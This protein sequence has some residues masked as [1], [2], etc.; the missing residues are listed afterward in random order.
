LA[1]AAVLR[2]NI[3]LY[4][5]NRVV[6]KVN[7]LIAPFAKAV[8]IQLPLIHQELK[9]SVPVPLFPWIQKQG[10]IEKGA[11]RRAYGL[12][13]DRFTILVFGG[14]QGAAFLNQLVPA[15]G[16]GEWQAIHMAGNEEAATEVRALY[17]EAGIVAAVKGFES[18]MGAAYQA[19]DLAICRSGAGT[20][21][22]LIRYQV[23]S[24]LIPYPTAADD[25]QRH[26]AEFLT[27]KGGAVWMAQSEATAARIEERMGKL[28]LAAM[29]LALA[30]QKE[31]HSAPM[32]ID[33]LVAKW[34]GWG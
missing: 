22:E 28:N 17:C 26:N 19:A 23:P 27:A 4:E 12:D 14:S 24:I 11:A 6:G 20:T 8:A 21:A 25:H 1:A 32:E 33:A 16:K 34:G 3:V 18:N 10:K 5:S 13:P 2:K 31:Q 30:T 15:M 7:R 9:Q 29:R